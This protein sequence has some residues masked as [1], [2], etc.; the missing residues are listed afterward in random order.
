MKLLLL[1]SVFVFSGFSYG[2]GSDLKAVKEL[3]QKINTQNE[4]V[5]NIKATL[6]NIS[7]VENSQNLKIKEIKERLKQSGESGAMD[8]FIGFQDNLRSA[9]EE[10]KKIKDTKQKV[11][12]ELS[13][14]EKKLSAS[15]SEFESMSAQVSRK[16][17]SEKEEL[18]FVASTCTFSSFPSRKIVA[19]PGCNSKDGGLCMATVTCVNSKGLKFDHVVTCSEQ[20]CGDGQVADCIGEKMSIEDFSPESSTNKNLKNSSVKKQ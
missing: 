18:G 20:N 5:E 16:L 9:S 2:Q 10:L 6:V 15:E 12:L 17:L 7:E 8:Q 13:T 14:A 11:E 3:N 1:L 19:A 4:I